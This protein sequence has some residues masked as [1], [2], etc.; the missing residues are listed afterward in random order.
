MELHTQAREMLKSLRQDSTDA[1]NRMWYLLRNRRLGGFKFRRQYPIGPY[2]AD[3]CC[4]EKRLII[5]LD[6]GQ[7]AERESSD[8]ARTRYL[9]YQGYRVM[10]FWNDQVLKETDAV[11]EMILTILRSKQHPLS[12]GERE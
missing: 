3:F 12:H 4:Y 7:H 1:E 11:C 5:E 6:G 9:E 8:E 2:I 10:R